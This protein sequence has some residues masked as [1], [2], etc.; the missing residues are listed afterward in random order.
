MGIMSRLFGAAAV[1]SNSDASL[2]EASSFSDR[3]KKAFEFLSFSAKEQSAAVQETMASIEEMR[4]MLSQTDQH[5]SRSQNLAEKAKDASS[6]RL[7]TVAK[8]QQAMSAIKETNVLL[9]ELQASFAAI[10]NK[11][12]VINDI[13]FKTQLLS[14]NASIEAARAGHFGK[15]FSVV[16]EEVGRLAQTS[17]KA[18]R[19][20]EALIADS[21]KKATDVVSKVISRA[22]EGAKVS[23][24]VI[25]SFHEMTQVIS[26]ISKS[27][28]AMSEASRDQ[29]QGMEQT[30]T[31]I[32]RISRLTEENRKNAESVLVMAEKSVGS[33]YD[34]ETSQEILKIVENIA[35]DANKVSNT[36]ELK[37]INAD[38]SSFRSQS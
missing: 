12:R 26:E 13:V 36:T 25:F 34:R 27:L 16:A 23:G 29:L 7:K 3:V 17:G 2:R 11:T 19:E 20:I 4:T 32:E 31:A 9:S 38:D 8:M 22:E 6:D 1:A 14:F 21:Q 24:E 33:Q 5:V 35:Q 10:K 15:G 37:N 30:T 28:N 18:S